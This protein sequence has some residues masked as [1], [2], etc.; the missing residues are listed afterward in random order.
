[1]SLPSHYTY[2]HGQLQFNQLICSIWHIVKLNENDDKPYGLVC[3]LQGKMLIIRYVSC[4]QRNVIMDFYIEHC[5]VID[6]KEPFRMELQWM[7]RLG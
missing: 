4:Q 5:L 3:E 6:Q 1:M 2:L 7:A